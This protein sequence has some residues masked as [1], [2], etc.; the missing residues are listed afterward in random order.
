MNVINSSTGA[1]TETSTSNSTQLAAY[2]RRV[3]IALGIT[4]WESGKAGGQVGKVNGTGAVIGNGDN[5]IDASEVKSVVPY[6]SSASNPTTFSKQFGGTWDSVIDYVADTSKADTITS[7]TGLS[8]RFEQYNP[9]H[10]VYGNPDLRWRFGLKMMVDYIQQNQNTSPGLAG[11]PQ[12]PFA[13][14][15]DGIQT[16]IG[17][18][19]S[20]QCDH[21][22]VGL[23]SFSQV[24][25]GPMDYPTIM[26]WLTIDFG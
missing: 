15:I 26:S 20:G 5:V 14:G 23:A 7:D 17:M 18:L 4:R 9:S 16:I 21:D 3:L 8:Y 22:Q 24:G 25:Y 12:L 19:Q 1:G 6:P 11:S 2:R 10:G 13:T